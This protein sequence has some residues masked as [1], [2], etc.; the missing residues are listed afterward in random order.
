MLLIDWL[1][2][3][4]KICEMSNQLTRCGRVC[5]AC[6]ECSLNAHSRLKEPDS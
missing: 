3:L 5:C 2:A 1:E 4:E 6:I